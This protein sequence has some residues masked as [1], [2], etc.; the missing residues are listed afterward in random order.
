GV[1]NDGWNYAID[2]DGR[3]PGSTFKP[4]IAYGPAIEY[5][6]LPTY[7]QLHDDKPYQLN[8]SGGK[9]INNYDGRFHGWMTMRTALSESFNVP[10][11]KL[12]EE[13]GHSNAQQFAENIGITFDDDQL[14]ATD[15]IGGGTGVTPLEL[16]GAY[17]A[18]AN[19][20]IYN[21]PYAV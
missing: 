1:K 13:V 19:E 7:Y 14:I 16:A 11:M 9:T 8:G 2:G 17:R 10:T 3:Q 18:F 6:K 15:A 4:I 20:G 5:N 21:E 12:F